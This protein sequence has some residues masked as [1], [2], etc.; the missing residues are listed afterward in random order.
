MTDLEG[1]HPGLAVL[2][3]PGEH[4]EAGDHV[5]V[6]HVLVGAAGGVLG[7]PLEDAVV[8]AAIGIAKLLAL[9]QRAD[10]GNERAEGADRL[11]G[12][13]RPVKAIPLARG[14]DHALGILQDLVAVA[15][16]AR[17]F[18]LGLYVS[19]QRLDR[20]ELVLADPPVEN[21][22]QA[23]RT[24]E[25]P[26]LSFAHDRHREGERLAPDRQDHAVVGLRQKR[27]CGAHRLKG[28]A[29]SLA[30]DRDVTAD[31][32]V[33]VFRAEYGPK[34]LAVV[35]LERVAQ[36]LRRRLG[37]WKGLRLGQSIRTADG[38]K[39]HQRGATTGHVAHALPVPGRR[40]PL[41]LCTGHHR[42][43]PPPPRL[44]PP[45]PR[46]ALPRLDD[47]LTLLPP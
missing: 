24:V 27:G 31:Q 47:F 6:D 5:A 23:R 10:L 39:E 1:H 37:R 19:P 38:H 9:D 30:Y 32:I 12:R 35:G 20:G 17:I 40:A 13:R 34:G 33:G 25:V 18:D 26:T 21:L 7:L 15:V 46:D 4:G 29:H 41:P 44:P 8:V 2:R 45:P 43:R 28:L 16:S 3:R 11:A 14:T 22:L 36:G 42:L